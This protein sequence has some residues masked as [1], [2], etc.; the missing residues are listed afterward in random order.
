MCYR[1]REIYPYLQV[2]LVAMEVTMVV[3]RECHYHESCRY[4]LPKKPTENEGK[5]LNSFIK[6]K[7]YVQLN[8]IKKGEVVKMNP[9]LEIYENFDE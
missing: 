3:A 5:D 7:D 2:E 1:G 9:I 6:L 4:M 8:I